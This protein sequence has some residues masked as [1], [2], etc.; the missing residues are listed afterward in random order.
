MDRETFNAII[1]CAWLFYALWG[2]MAKQESIVIIG[3]VCSQ[4]W[5]NAD[6]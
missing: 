3:I 1:V 4:V 5:L 6:G 2:I